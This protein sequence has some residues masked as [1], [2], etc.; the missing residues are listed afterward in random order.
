MEKGRCH[1]GRQPQ[2]PGAPNHAPPRQKNQLEEHGEKYVAKERPKIGPNLKKA[3]IA[4]IFYDGSWVLG[5][6]KSVKEKKVGGA[7]LHNGP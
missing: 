6:I 4:K 1:N 5:R 7:L 3:R 2:G